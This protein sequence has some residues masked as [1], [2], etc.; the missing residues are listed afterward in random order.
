MPD[1][2]SVVKG[3]CSQIH[4]LLILLSMLIFWSISV[5]HTA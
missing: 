5:V 4:F 2:T 1:M 3:N